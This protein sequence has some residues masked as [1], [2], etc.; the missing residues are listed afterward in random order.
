M[1]PCVEP[2]L[3]GGIVLPSAHAD[4]N[5]VVNVSPDSAPLRPGLVVCP[6]P[7]QTGCL[8]LFMRFLRNMRE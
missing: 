3:A 5:E 8:V 4:Y 6:L 1:A 2:A 7:S